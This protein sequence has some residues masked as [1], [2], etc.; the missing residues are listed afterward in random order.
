M[1]WTL[2]YK[3]IFSPKRYYICNNKDIL[4]KNK[5][6]YFDYWFENNILVVS[7]LLN[8]DGVVLTNKDFFNKFKIPVRPKE[9]AVVMDAIPK[10]VLTL[11]K[12]ASQEKYLIFEE[13]KSKIL[14]GNTNIIRNRLSNNYIRNIL[15][16]IVYPP[17]HFL[18]SSVFGDVNWRKAWQT[19]DKFF[20]NKKVKEV[21]FKIMHRIYPVKRAETL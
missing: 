21:S 15:N 6:L 12:S 20:I 1:A 19:V 13:I 3:H 11:L 4:Y 17:A 10:N 7:Q 18:W 2:A 9:F 14:T 5:S 8:N 16:N